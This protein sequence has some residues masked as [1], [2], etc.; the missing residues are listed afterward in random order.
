MYNVILFFKHPPTSIESGIIEMTRIL[1][2][3]E[4][5]LPETNLD[6]LWIIQF[7]VSLQPVGCGERDHYQNER[8][9]RAHDGGLARPRLPHHSRASLECIRNEGW[10]KR[11]RKLLVFAVYFRIP[12][13]THKYVTSSR[14]TGSLAQRANARARCLRRLRVP[15]C[16]S[17]SSGISTT[18]PSPVLR[19]NFLC[20]LKKIK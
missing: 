14:L 13:G 19:R 3:L 5:Y 9:R 1:E 6:E 16:V 8:H 17:P 4:T 7:S 12:P 18:F 10:W 15:Q 2:S 20:P 11:K